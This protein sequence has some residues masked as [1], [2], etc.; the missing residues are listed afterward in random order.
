M[1]WL[2]PTTKPRACEA[3][4]A[5]GKPCRCAG[6]IQR[7]SL[8]ILG[9]EF[10]LLAQVHQHRNRDRASFFKMILRSAGS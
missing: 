8:R 10:I 5:D 3:T 2:K 1:V 7:P 9:N 6:Q 4:W